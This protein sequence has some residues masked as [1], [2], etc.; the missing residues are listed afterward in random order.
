MIAK[1]LFEHYA[2]IGKKRYEPLD[3]E[4]FCE[5]DELV[6]RSDFSNMP[7][8]GPLMK[9]VLQTPW[10]RFCKE[11]YPDEF[12]PGDLFFIS[13]KLTHDSVPEE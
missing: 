1:V 7:V 12:R 13:H 11:T 2:M 9:S 8:E 5:D 3:T 6:F 10:G 4:W